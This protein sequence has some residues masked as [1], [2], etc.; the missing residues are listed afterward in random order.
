M[1][2]AASR[3]FRP[4]SPTGVVCGSILVIIRAAGCPRSLRCRWSGRCGTGPSPADAREGG[5]VG[6]QGHRR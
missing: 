1:G 2:A 4:L 5:T 3:V 6:D